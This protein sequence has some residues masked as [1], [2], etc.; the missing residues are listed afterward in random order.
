MKKRS[1]IT[2]FTTAITLI[3][4]SIPAIAAEDTKT[5]ESCPVV[6]IVIASGAHESTRTDS[7][8]NIRG[9]AHGV[10]FAAEL[11]DA[12]SGTVSAWQL[13]YSSSVTV[14]GS[15][16]D[17]RALTERDKGYLPYGASRAEGV[18]LTS[19]HM[20][21]FVTQCPEAQ[22]ILA[23]YSQGASVIGDTVAA[24][25]RGTVQGVSVDSILGTYLLADPG[26]SRAT[27]EEVLLQDGTRGLRSATGEILVP[28]D[29]GTPPATYDGLTGPRSDGA[30]SPFGDRVMSFCHPLDPACATATNRLPQRLGQTLNQWE[31]TPDHT[32]A[33]KDALLTPKVLSALLLVSLPLLILTSL[34]FYSPIPGL[35]DSVSGITGLNATQSAALRALA[36]EVT[37]VGRVAKSY[38]REQSSNTG[39]AITPPVPEV[40]KLSTDGGSSQASRLSSVAVSQGLKGSYHLRY[41]TKNTG[42]ADGSTKDGAGPFTVGGKIVDKWIHDDMELRIVGALAAKEQPLLTHP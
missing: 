10:N 33:A 38:D 40:D 8:Q 24:I 11:Q 22:F 17:N 23:G 6:H 41:F 27:K 34:G 25:G 9:F 14:M 21:E 15:A 1:V 19:Q 16:L 29:Q 32:I 35:I 26:R 28:V 37:V 31:D 39:P 20:S 13:P 4:S 18:R 36:S 3:A 30:F 7:P 2:A 12:Y 5:A 42:N